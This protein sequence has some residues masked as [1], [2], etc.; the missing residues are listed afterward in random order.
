MIR[1]DAIA[2]RGIGPFRDEIRV[3]L[4]SISGRLVAVTGENGAGKS[5]L[6]ELLAGALYR[7]CPTRGALAALATTRDSFVEV[8]AVNGA[9]WTIRQTV[10]AI[11]GKGESMVLDALGAPALIAGKVREFDGWA[12][13]HLPPREVLFASTLAVQGSAGFVEMKPGERKALLLRVLGIEWYER[14]AEVARERARDAREAM[15]RAAARRAEVSGACV[16][17]ATAE[18]ELRD[19]ERGVEEWA[20]RVRQA[21]E[22]ARH[23][24]AEE[25]RIAALVEAARTAREYR[26]ELDAKLTA[27]RAKVAD[28]EARARNNVALLERTEE[29]RG[30]VRRAAELREQL[31]AA[32]ADMLVAAEQARAASAQVEPLA[33][34]AREIEARV[35]VLGDRER[36]AHDVLRG[37]DAVRAAAAQVF[38]LEASVETAS[39]A[40]DVAQ[41]ALEEQRERRLAGADDR[42]ATLRA[43]LQSTVNLVDAGASADEIRDVSARTLEQDDAAV[44]AAR[45][46]PAAL[47]AAG[48][49]VRS[50]RENLAH[51]SDTL[52]VARERASRLPAIEAAERE[53]VDIGEEL[54]TLDGRS[55]DLDARQRDAGSARASADATANAST[56]AARAIRAELESLAKVL[57]LVPKLDA[58]EGRLAELE[59]QLESARDAV[60]TLACELE[61]VPE[62]APIPPAPDVRA[63]DEASAAAEERARRAHGAVA[64]TQRQLEHARATAERLAAL[65]AERADLESE[66]ADWTRLAADLG[67]DGLQAMEIDAAGPELS[68]TINDLLHTCVSSRW[69][70]TIDTTRISADGK[71]VL[72][73][74]EVRVLDT[75]R[76]REAPVETFSG[77]ERVLIGEAVSLALAMLAARKS[78][79]EGVTL[80]RDESGAALDPDRSRSYVAMLRRAADQV[81]ASRVLL[82]SHSPEVV[83]LCDARIEIAGGKVEVRP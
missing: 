13:Q 82:V 48:D 71:R 59:P 7:E 19:A 49:A 29:I 60:D 15:E 4:S 62:P 80:V 2:A 75:E 46:A 26:T 5:T 1:F 64:V 38:A 83:D 10:D 35:R 58:A 76:G 69:T 54:R 23:A 44:R 30:A 28:L 81:G 36:R 70:V 42:V 37:R 33:R 24:R 73:G 65:D 72:E 11:T 50:A 66:L 56:A 79:F 41:R 57:E 40:V 78:G 21:Q 77:G 3:D 63:A 25:A 55:R 32:D 51:A 47:A 8:R 45:E 31:A 9:P 12:A 34:E 14:L 6:L 22:A 52:R 53:L 39:A 43:A 61:M 18:A 20:E 67:R 74:L 17:V 27:A 68:A 16:D